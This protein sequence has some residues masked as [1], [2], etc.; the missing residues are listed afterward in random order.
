MKNLIFSVSCLFLLAVLIT[1]CQKDL[2]G[3]SEQNQN[4]TLEDEELSASFRIQLA[5]TFNSLIKN[6]EVNDYLLNTIG[7]D[8]YS[9]AELA[10]NT[11]ANLLSDAL[12][13]AEAPVSEILENDPLLNLFISFPNE[14]YSLD[15]PISKLVVVLEKDVLLLDTHG[16]VTQMHEDDEMNEVAL[17]LKSSEFLVAINKRNYQD[18]NGV[19]YSNIKNMMHYATPIFTTNEYEIFEKSALQ[20]LIN[21]TKLI[22]SSSTRSDDGDKDP[23]DRDCNNGVQDLWED[24]VDCGG[25]FC[26]PCITGETCSDGVQNGWETGIDCGGPFCPPCEV[27]NGFCGELA[28]RDVNPSKDYLHKFKFADCISYKKIKELREGKRYEMRVDIIFAN[29]NGEVTDLQKTKRVHKRDLV[30]TNAIGWCIGTKYYDF[31]PDLDIVTWNIEDYGNAM[32]YIWSESDPG[33]ETEYEFGIK[34]VIPVGQIPL[35][36]TA[37]VNLKFTNEDDM[38]GESVVE[39]CDNTEG[40][41]TAYSTGD[42]AFY[43]RQH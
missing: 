8:E 37:S 9:I 42:I 34:T 21:I 30:E 27:Y 19:S 16:N 35:P 29:E 4:E 1:S 32:K 25:P 6:S 43:V 5:Q 40:E 28:D 38:L 24:G 15:Q 7:D 17:V 39:Y 41:G 31:D 2:L 18:I 10:G 23:E 33:N 12:E 13:S 3:T 36:V 20:D 11:K 26:P 22:E 14:Q